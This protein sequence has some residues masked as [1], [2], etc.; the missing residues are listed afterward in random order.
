VQNETQEKSEGKQGDLWGE[1]RLRAV[2]H[3]ALLE[4]PVVWGEGVRVRG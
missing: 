1:A 3:V 2:Q 4:A